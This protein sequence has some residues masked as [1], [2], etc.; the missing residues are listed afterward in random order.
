MLSSDDNGPWD[1]GI[2]LLS[3]GSIRVTYVV[4]K[5]SASHLAA[6]TVFTVNPI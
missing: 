3:F 2:L 4:T 6:R 5:L 1:V